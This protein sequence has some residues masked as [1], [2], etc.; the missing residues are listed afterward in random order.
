M[1]YENGTPALHWFNYAGI[2]TAGEMDW[3]KEGEHPIP[4]SETELNAITMMEFH[5][6]DSLD[7]T[8]TDAVDWPAID[9]NDLSVAS[10]MQVTNPVVK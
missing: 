9:T 7:L 1:E 5:W 10:F 6:M 8:Q 2:A 3:N 4:E